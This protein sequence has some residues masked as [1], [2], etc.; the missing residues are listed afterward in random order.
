MEAA[1]TLWIHASWI[2]PLLIL[3]AYL[4]SPRFRGDVAERQVRRLLGVQLEK[5]RYTVF[6]DVRLPFA[7][8]TIQIDHVIVSATGIFV[9]E[10]EALRGWI[11]GTAVQDRWKQYRF[12]RFRYFDNPLHR[13]TLQVEALQQLLQLPASRFHRFVVLTGHKGFKSGTPV[14]VLHP[15]ELLRAIRGKQAPL[16]RPETA[17]AAVKALHETALKRP[18]GFWVSPHAVLRL[19]LVAVLFAGAYLAFRDDISGVKADWRLRVEMWANPERFS[20]EGRRKTERELWEESL[21][22]A[23]S[24]DTG[25]CACYEPDGTRVE[26]EAATCR[27]L[28]ERG[29]VPSPRF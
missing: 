1:R 22:C 28:A 24:P 5:S 25:R 26:L 6:N 18:G 20:Q 12:G 11:S 23:T 13:N 27:T 7:G 21:V 15:N 8:G 10:S 3:L 4:S 29:T 14:N 9:I 17:A 2:V 16:L 19:G